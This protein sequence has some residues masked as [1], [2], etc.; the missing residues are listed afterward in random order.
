MKKNIFII[1]AV[2]TLVLM[3]VTTLAKSNHD[4]GVNKRKQGIARSEKN[5]QKQTQKMCSRGER[6]IKRNID[7]LENLIDKI[8]SS[9][10]LES[11]EKKNLIDEIK[12]DIDQLKYLQLNL[13]TETDKQKLQEIVKSIP[14]RGS[15]LGKYMS[16]IN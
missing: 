12:L 8:S 2:M 9:R 3:P 7:L 4:E 10:K 1:L 11:D 13:N 16:R 6:K 14:S 15:L 5:L